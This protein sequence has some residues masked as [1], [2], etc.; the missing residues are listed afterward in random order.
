MNLWEIRWR[1]KGQSMRNEI[2]KI[3]KGNFS[4]RFSRNSTNNES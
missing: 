3:L 1:M 4:D 2:R